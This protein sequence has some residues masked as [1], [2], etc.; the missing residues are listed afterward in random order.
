MASKDLLFNLY[1]KL[2][3]QRA[4]LTEA[5]ELTIEIDEYTVDTYPEPL[6]EKDCAAI[7]SYLCGIPDVN[8]VTADQ[9]LK[10]VKKNYEDQPFWKNIILDFL[11]YKLRQQKEANYKRNIELLK[12]TTRILNEIR[13]EENRR[14][15]L[16]TSFGDKIRKA[17]FR[18][19][20]YKLINCY[21][22]MYRKDS[23]KAYDTLITNPAYFSP[24]ITM[25]AEGNQILTPSEAIEEN[26]K[27]AKFL[28]ELKI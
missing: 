8:D 2:Y 23:K 3:A 21:F 28:K 10:I 12:E 15:S 16:V 14:K 18:V 20:G 25:D 4:V 22:I 17:G 7:V 19:D 11:E 9:V 27:L 24:I 1:Q 13:Q 5:P 26:K 6:A